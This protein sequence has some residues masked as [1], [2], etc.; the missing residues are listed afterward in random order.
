M[1]RKSTLPIML[2]IVLLYLAGGMY[3]FSHTADDAFISL[4]YASNL[5]E[6]GQLSYNPGERPAEGF[7][8]L[9]LV[10]IEALFMALGF[11]DPVLVPKLVGLLSGVAVI[12]AV[13]MMSG[14]IGVARDWL[15]LLTALAVAASTPFIVWSVGGLE[16]VLFTALVTA[17]TGFH[18]ASLD[19]PGKR[20]ALLLSDLCF[21]LSVLTRPE[22]LLFWG[23]S[24]LFTLARWKTS[25]PATRIPSLVRSSAFLLIYLAWKIWYFGD[26]FPL[27]YYAKEPARD[28]EK[29]M[30]GLMRAWCL[31]KTNF[32]L[33]YAP[34]FGLAAARAIV[35]R[36]ARMLY[37]LLPTL[38]YAAYVVS[39]GDRVPMDHVFRFWVPVL[40][41][42]YLAAAKGMENA[43]NA[44][45]L[46]MRRIAPALMAVI[47]VAQVVRGA[48]DLHSAWSR[49]MEFGGEGFYRGIGLGDLQ[50][51]WE[52]CYLAMGRWL[53]HAA[54]RGATLVMADVGMVPYYSQLRVIDVFSLVTKEIVLL[55]RERRKW[56]KN[57]PE[58]RALTERLV[59]AVFR[60]NSEYLV[61]TGG[62]PL[63]E[64]PRSRRYAPVKIFSFRGQERVV[65]GRIDLP[66]AK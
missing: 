57:S 5:V 24:H 12:A 53:R 64:D 56:P 1:L 55:R 25:N 29:I 33:L 39:M 13:W 47:M 63:L 38:A 11:P 36:D 52:H 28:P 44:A 6:D 59:D 7:T 2:V 60:D 42:F 66:L 30:A 32:N 49:D 46:P 17:G 62:L 15:R 21:F 14:F 65:W 22:G 8:N 10:L 27:T 34:F 3:V 16:T 19:Q 51:D 48:V 41:L 18:L 26:I 40:P 43:L 35:R 45:P 50:R 61:Q 23:L 4:R 54:P 31:L 9:L 20:A 58:Y 37:L